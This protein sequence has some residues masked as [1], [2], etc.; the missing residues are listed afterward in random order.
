VT[1]EYLANYS[2]W[3][4]PYY[5]KFLKLF[6]HELFKFAA[7]SE[8]FIFR[9]TKGLNAQEVADR[10]E[11]YQRLFATIFLADLLS[12]ERQIP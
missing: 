9:V 8:H 3:E 11:N 10:L 6:I 7:D 2:R 1:C 5:G 4:K 12:I